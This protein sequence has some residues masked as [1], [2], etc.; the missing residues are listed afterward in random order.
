MKKYVLLYF[1]LL[2]IS[3]TMSAQEYFMKNKFE[4]IP[5]NLL[6]HI[7]EMGMD[8][9]LLLTELE[10][11]YFNALYQVNEKEFNLS[12]KKVGFLTGNVGKNKSNKKIYFEGE[13]SRLKLN[14]SPLFG[15]LYIFNSDQKAEN[16]GYDAAIV[17]YTKKLLSI[18]EVIK[19]LKEKH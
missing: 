11:Q 9:C 12:G 6:S 2:I 16:G 18:K 14:H 13:R 5:Q 4:N 15:K 1:V 10:G 7:D 8:E 3:T 17:Y 19:R